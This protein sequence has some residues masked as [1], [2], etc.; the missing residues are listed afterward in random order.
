MCLGLPVF[1][2]WLAG[3]T[4]KNHTLWMAE[5]RKVTQG[6]KTRQEGKL[7]QFPSQEPTAKFVLTDTGLVRTI[8]W[9]SLQGWLEEQAYRDS[10]FVY[11]TL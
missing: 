7:I 10:R 2:D 5:T 1:S 8:K 11:S 6:H 9:A 3:L 4:L